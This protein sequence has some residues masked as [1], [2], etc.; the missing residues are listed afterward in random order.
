MLLEENRRSAKSLQAW[1]KNSWWDGHGKTAN[2]H[3]LSH[4]RIYS[5]MFPKPPL[6]HWP[7]FGLMM[8]CLRQRV[9]GARKGDMQLGV[10]G[11]LCTYSYP[12]ASR[13]IA[14]A[15]I[16]VAFAFIFNSS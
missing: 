11:C 1:F 10:R 5:S 4:V 3:P 2:D 12:I 9:S 6:L 7:L 14:G 15:N 8:M 16:L 13:A